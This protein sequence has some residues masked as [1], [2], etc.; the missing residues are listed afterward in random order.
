MSN[1]AKKEEIRK[2]LEYAKTGISVR[3]K[4][5]QWAEAAQDFVRMIEEEKKEQEP[6]MQRIE[7]EDEEMLKKMGAK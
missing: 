6:K 3:K 4:E 7:R 5:A 2:D 1:K